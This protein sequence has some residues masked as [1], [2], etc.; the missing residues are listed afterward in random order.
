M[1]AS[2][3]TSQL[4]VEQIIIKCILSNM[5]ITD[6]WTICDSLAVAFGLCSVRIWPVFTSFHRLAFKSF[7]FSSV[8][9]FI[10]S[11]SLSLSHGS[12][13]DLAT[14]P[15]SPSPFTMTHRPSSHMQ[16]E[17]E[18]GFDSFLWSY[19]APTRMSRPNS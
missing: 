11:L 12:K 2:G 17:L 19:V 13:Y 18:K 14:S 5:N 1:N 3:P 9:V 8:A 16:R 6:R 15:P 10:S 4:N 7:S